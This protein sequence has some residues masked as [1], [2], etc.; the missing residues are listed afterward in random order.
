MSMLLSSTFVV[1]PGSLPPGVLVLWHLGEVQGYGG[2]VGLWAGAL[3]WDRALD[4][5]TL[6]LVV[7]VQKRPSTLA[8]PARDHLDHWGMLVPSLLCV[9]S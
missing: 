1:S 9:T 3:S 8:W 2:G 7:H 4:G 5:S 6:V